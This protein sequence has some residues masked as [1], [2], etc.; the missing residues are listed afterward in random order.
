MNFDNQ[1]K[2]WICSIPMTEE[3]KRIFHILWSDL[4]KKCHCDKKNERIK[5]FKDFAMGN[6]I[7]T[8]KNIVLDKGILI[9]KGLNPS[10]RYNIHK[11][12]DNIGFHHKSIGN[13]KIKTMYI[14]YPENFT[15]VKNIVNSE[16]NPS[17]I[18]FE[19]NY[20]NQ[21]QSLIFK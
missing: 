10:K 17:I 5:L 8:S 2:I 19:H 6:D 7:K 9:I 15:L 13:G 3:E 20:T 18:D 4:M 11:I 12:C 21:K 1:R 14:I 16:N